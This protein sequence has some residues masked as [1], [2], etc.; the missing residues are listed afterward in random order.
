MLNVLIQPTIEG[1]INRTFD[2]YDETLP[3]I[4]MDKVLPN[5]TSIVVS[6][7]ISGFILSPIEL[8]RVR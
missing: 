7:T 2:L 6:Y 8:V 5:L 4:Q 3:L 1:I